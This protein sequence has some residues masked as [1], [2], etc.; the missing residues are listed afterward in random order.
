MKDQKAP[1]SKSFAI[2]APPLVAMAT[3]LAASFLS[4]SCGESGFKGAAIPSPTP[5]PEPIV[6]KPVVKPVITGSNVVAIK[7]APGEAPAAMGPVVPVGSEAVKFQTGATVAF[8]T[9]AGTAIQ[10]TAGT[11]ITGPQV[12]TFTATGSATLKRV[13]QFSQSNGNVAF[14]ARATTSCTTAGTAGC[15]GLNFPA[16]GYSAP[17]EVFSVFTQPD[18]S[19]AAASS[20]SLGSVAIC[21]RSL[22]G[23]LPDVVAIPAPANLSSFASTSGC[24]SAEI[25]VFYTP[26]AATEGTVAIYKWTKSIGGS[27]AFLFSKSNA[28]VAGFT[29]S[30]SIP[31]FYAYP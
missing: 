29:L 11:A 22:L 3:L 27:S 10:A 16:L 25:E 26:M 24:S 20:A 18:A 31:A 30:S 12:S 21:H 28:G 15:D 5:S 19:A 7:D 9:S 4:T 17:T 1:L 2:V 6:E 14:S 8:Q 13:V 23:A